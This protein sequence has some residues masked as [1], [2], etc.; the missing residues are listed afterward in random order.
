MY[1]ILLDDDFFNNYIQNKLYLKELT[2]FL[3]T[4]SDLNFIVF[5]PYNKTNTYIKAYERIKFEKDLMIQKKTI[6]YNLDLVQESND[7]ELSNLNLSSTFIGKINLVKSIESDSNLIIPL[8]L[9]KHNLSPMLKSSRGYIYYIRHFCK[10]IN[11]NISKWIFNNDNVIIVDFPSDTT[12]FPAKN[13][14]N[15]YDELRSQVLK[16]SSSKNKVASFEEIGF[17]VALRNHYVYDS[18]LTSLNFK[19]SHSKRKVF[20]SQGT[21]L[22]YLSIDFENGGF[23]VYDKNARHLGQYRFNGKFE[24]APDSKSH[25]L[26]LK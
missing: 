4:Y 26:Y 7:I 14:C 9:D 24:K 12:I 15:G 5:H 6:K 23:E 21:T 25:P 11:S 17:E 18:K 1:K 10:E 8:S 19:K 20:V 16:S 2:E 13:F 22:L 3:C